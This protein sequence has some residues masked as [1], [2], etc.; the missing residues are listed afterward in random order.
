CPPPVESFIGRRDILNQMH[1]YFRSNNNCQPTFVL[2]GLGGSG[3]SQLAL[4]F[5]EESTQYVLIVYSKYLFSNVFYVDATNEQTLQTDLESIA[6]E[7][8]GQSVDES[9]CWLASQAK[10]SQWLLLF[11]NADDVDLKLNKF[12]PSQ[13]GNILIT[14]RNNELRTYAGKD[15]DAKVADMDHEDAINLLLYQA[16]EEQN[17]ENKVMIQE[18]HYFALAISQAGA[19]IHCHFS[20]KEYLA[21]Y[22]R[23][24]NHLLDEVQFQNQ[25]PYERA[26]Y[27][28][29]KLS[30]SRLDTS[31]KSFL[32]ICSMLHHE[33]I[34]EKIFEKASLANV[35]LG[36]SQL[37]NTVN[38]LLSHLGK[39][40]T[41]SGSDKWDTWKFQKIIRHLRSYSLIE[42]D[43]QNHT[44]SIHPLVQ[45]W[46]DT[47]QEKDRY[48]MHKCVLGIIALSITLEVGNTENYK[49]LHTLPPHI[50]KARE[51]LNIGEITP[52]VLQW[53]GYVYYNQ[54]HWKEAEKLWV[55]VME[56]RK[57]VLGHNHPDT[58]S[59]MANLASTYQNQGHWKE[60]EK[61]QAEVMEKRKQLLGDNH[62]HTLL[63]MANLASTYRNQGHW[64]EAEKL[65]VEVMEKSKQLLG[66]NHP[67]TLSSMANLASTYRNQGHID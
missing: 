45:H 16:Q 28:T 23:E 65:E 1:L 12:F 46:N 10:N 22:L 25:D 2:H 14:T 53:I 64:K 36:D 3:K 13:C 44:Y 59:S 5:V 15:G 61:L 42:Y 24:R 67:H 4:K 8:V 30:Y 20:L 55:E 56:K 66:D 26:V 9:L 49:Y 11:D 31:A 29:W 63:S 58:L 7:N 50:L 33:G 32:Q 52:L 34:S 35:K 47:I 38:E 43:N 48:L 62:P 60:A 17:A 6:P 39:Q 41:D 54:G 51:L 57:Q 21:F 18:L 27:A 19:Y 40:K 37:E